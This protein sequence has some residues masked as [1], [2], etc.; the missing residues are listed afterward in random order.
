MD[1]VALLKVLR[2]FKRWLSGPSVDHTD[3][4]H[5]LRAPAAG[6]VG[7]DCDAAPTTAP[8]VTDASGGLWPSAA[9]TKQSLGASLRRHDGRRVRLFEG[10]VWYLGVS[11][12]QGPKTD[13]IYYDPD[14]KDCQK[15]SRMFGNSQ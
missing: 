6:L 10:G 5:R 8:P 9:S 3:Q 13:P 4:R 12:N 15:G 11:K 1:Q 14:C 2:T 7:D